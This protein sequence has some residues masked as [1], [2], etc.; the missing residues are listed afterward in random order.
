M[1]R[2]NQDDGFDQTTPQTSSE[3]SEEFYIGTIEYAQGS[4]ASQPAIFWGHLAFYGHVCF[5]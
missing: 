4:I 1:L 5:L 2:E 3:E